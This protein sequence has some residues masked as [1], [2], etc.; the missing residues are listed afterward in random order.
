[1]I[2]AQQLKHFSGTCEYYQGHMNINYTDGVMYLCE[3]GASWV[4]SDIAAICKYKLRNFE[5]INI[6]V[7][8]NVKR[9]SC[10]IHYTDGNGLELYRQNYRW[11]D[12]KQDIKLFY[13]DNVLMLASEY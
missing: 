4:A 12:L 13:V 3:N 7:K 9:G 1:M 11:T 8:V 5:F 2:D 10:T 6:D